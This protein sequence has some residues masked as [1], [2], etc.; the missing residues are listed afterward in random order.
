MTA[1]NPTIDVRLTEEDINAIQAAINTRLDVLESAMAHAANI[2][3]QKF[4]EN[5]IKAL[6]LADRKID[7]S[8]IKGGA[9]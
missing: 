2:E 3:G 4:W 5:R 6:M 7:A 1:T 9:K 8:I